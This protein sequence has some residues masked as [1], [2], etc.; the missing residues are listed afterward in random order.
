MSSPPVGGSVAG[1]GMDAKRAEN[2]PK[3]GTAKK[4]NH[5]QKNG[6]NSMFTGGKQYFAL[7]TGKKTDLKR[8]NPDSN[9]ED[10]ELKRA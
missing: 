5:H 8:A 2:R 10:F 3:K 1:V 6:F 9:R 4:G 7:K